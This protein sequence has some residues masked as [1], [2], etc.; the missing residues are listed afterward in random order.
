MFGNILKF[1]KKEMRL[2]LK[3]KNKLI[4]NLSA[5]GIL[6]ILNY[7]LPLM[8]LP[9]LVRVLGMEN[10]GAFLFSQALISYFMI[11]VDFGFDLYATRKISIHRKNKNMIEEIV[12]TVFTWKLLFLILSF[13]ILMVLTIYIPLLNQYQ[14]LHLLN[15]GMILG[16][17]LFSN[18]YYQGIENMKL[19]TIF[20]ASAKIFFTVLLFAFIKQP[21]DLQL[22]AFINSCGYLL[23]GF[24]SLW[25]IHIKHGIKFRIVSK[26]QL[27]ENL[28]ESAPFFWSRIA[29]SIY[30]V[31]NTF[32]I[33]LVLGNT[34]AGIFG[35]ADK[36]FRGILAL[37][38]PLNTVFYPYMAHQKNIIMFKKVIKYVMVIILFTT[39][40]LF[41]F[42]E[43][44][45][46]LIFGM[47]FEGSIIL[48]KIFSIIIIYNLPSML[49]GYPLLGALGHSRVVNLSVV[50]A[51]L[52]HIILLVAIIP[53]LNLEL[54]ALL[55]AFTELFV[56]LYRIYFVKKYK[57]L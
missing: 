13:S 9:Y 16:T 37:F 29:V 53:I 36:I 6:Q 38:S 31:S 50:F 3:G 4:E 18:F 25:I 8:T 34:A 39:L 41:I 30:T 52:L 51:S 24:I 43:N 28:K 32:V 55:V 2:T 15:F 19:I 26:K 40:I 48:L 57:L 21:D 27:I 54:V 56:F 23:V 42:A 17:I 10:Y 7:I 22:M 33:G 11:F 35:S 14:S 5:L 44:I 45:I 49:I 12:S 1:L 20:N 47:D 46:T